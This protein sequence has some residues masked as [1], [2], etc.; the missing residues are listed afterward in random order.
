VLAILIA[1]AGVPAPLPLLV[2][3]LCGAAL[4]AW[5][6]GRRERHA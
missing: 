4:G 1:R 5:Q 2:G 6:D 3:A